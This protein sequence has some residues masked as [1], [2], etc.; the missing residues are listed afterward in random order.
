MFSAFDLQ[1]G[2]YF[3][4]GRNSRTEEECRQ[5]IISWLTESEISVFIEDDEPLTDERVEQWY[6]DLW[7]DVDFQKEILEMYEVEIEEHEEPIED[8]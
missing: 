6:A 5:D 4:T 8:W 3:H 1:I 2:H 7:K